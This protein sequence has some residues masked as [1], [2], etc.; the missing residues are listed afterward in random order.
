[1][2]GRTIAGV[3]L[4]ALVLGA[5]GRAAVYAEPFD[6][7]RVGKGAELAAIGNCITCHTSPDGK[8]FA[9]G[10]AIDTPFG[11]IY[12]TNITPDAETGIGRWTE[13]DFRT[14]MHEGVDREGRDLYLAFPY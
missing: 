12:S 14:A 6:R 10:R 9:G 8:P 13:S 5:S 4:V 1:M 11:T 3:T 7:E 2:T